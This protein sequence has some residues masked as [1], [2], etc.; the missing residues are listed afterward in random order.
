MVEALG[1]PDWAEQPRFGTLEGRLANQDAL[2][3]CLGETTRGWDRYA[4]VVSRR[5]D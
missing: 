5:P 4:L 2:D 3:A 1:N